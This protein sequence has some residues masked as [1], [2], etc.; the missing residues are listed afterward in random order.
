MM[1]PID[2]EC[3]NFVPLQNDTFHN[4][5]QQIFDFHFNIDDSVFEDRVTIF[6][7]YAL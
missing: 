1:L 4:Y 5:S 6:V 7:L 3:I 2:T